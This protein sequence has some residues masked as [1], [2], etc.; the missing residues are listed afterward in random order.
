MKVTLESLKKAVKKK[1]GRSMAFAWLADFQHASGDFDGALKNIENGLSI[2]PNDIPAL[3]V[4]SKILFDKKDYAGCVRECLN[5]LNKDPFC[6]SAQKRLGDAYDKLGKTDDRNKSYRRVHDM[7]P[8]DDFWKEEYDVVSEEV[9]EVDVTPAASTSTGRFASPLPAEDDPFA[10]LSKG[11]E[12]AD[13]IEDESLD[14]L[15]ETLNQALA[16][17]DNTEDSVAEELSA[18]NELSGSDLS[19][20]FSNI[21]GDDDSETTRSNDSPFSRKAAESAPGENSVAA[22]AAMTGDVPL[23]ENSQG[24]GEAFGSIFGNDDLP[25]ENSGDGLFQK[26]SEASSGS[27]EVFGAFGGGDEVAASAAETADKPQ[28]VD[29]AFG[30]IFGDDD[31]PEEKPAE[32]SGMF[33]KSASSDMSFSEP[34]PAAETPVADKPQSVDDAFGSIFGDDDLPEEKPVAEASTENSSFSDSAEAGFPFDEP[35]ATPAAS[36][37]AEES[38]AVDNAF[39]SM[40]GDDD[41]PEEKPAESVGGMFDKSADESLSLGEPATATASAS[42]SVE[43]SDVANEIGGAFASMFGGDDNSDSLDVPAEGNSS[44]ESTGALFEE[45]VNAQSAEAPSADLDSLN[46][47]VS[48]AFKGLFDSDDDNLSDESAPNNSGVDFLMSGDSDD[49]V[50]ASLIKDPEA[51]LDRG[52]VDLDDSLNTR[53]LADIYMEQ[54][55]YGKALEIYQDLLKREPDNAEIKSKYAQV[56]KLYREKFGENL[57]G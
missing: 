30:S 47:E 22:P 43:K 18:T 40:F 51:P 25:E 53:T 3:L 26:S 48:G 37:P 34:A 19:S 20:A 1:K 35:A 50:A 10:A 49:E 7:D 36:A 8:L 45:S 14:A 23:E 57:N 27:D 9:P 16:Q 17:T 6:L 41:L 42:E 28:S 5:V 56:Q 21:F 15:Q 4:R 39:S 33:D 2:Y 52:A 32:T 12:S 46:S 44:Q 13:S 29:D 54:G 24:L 11:I 38:G 31:L 55:V